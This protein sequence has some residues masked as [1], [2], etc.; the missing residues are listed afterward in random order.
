MYDFDFWWNLTG[1][2]ASSFA[3]VYGAVETVK[4]IYK[5]CRA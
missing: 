1:L 3:F 4:E 5:N 2:V